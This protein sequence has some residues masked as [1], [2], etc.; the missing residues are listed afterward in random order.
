MKKEEE[1]YDYKI[2]LTTSYEEQLRRI[3]NRN[4]K[5]SVTIFKEKWIPLEEKYFKELNIPAH[6]DCYFT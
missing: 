6:C 1:K 4:R 3:A 5:D 2:F